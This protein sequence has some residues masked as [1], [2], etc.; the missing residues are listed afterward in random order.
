MVQVETA[1]GGQRMNGGIK[2]KANEANA[3]AHGKTGPPWWAM[4]VQAKS[5][6]SATRRRP[7]P[8]RDGLEKE[9]A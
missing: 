2:D 3:D 7:C 6:S 1:P 4:V 8:Y 9:T 5:M